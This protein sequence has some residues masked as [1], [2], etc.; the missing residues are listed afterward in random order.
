[1]KSQNISP[2]YHKLTRSSSLVDLSH[3]FLLS[4]IQIPQSEQPSMYHYMSGERPSSLITQ[5]RCKAFGTRGGLTLKTHGSSGL[6]LTLD[7]LHTA[8]RRYSHWLPCPG[9]SSLSVVRF[10][11]ATTSPQQASSP[12]AFRCCRAPP[13]QML[14]PAVAH[15]PKKKPALWISLY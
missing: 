14:V 10:A 8:V 2:S 3:S 12:R 9:S 5:S 7:F 4:V 13:P 15:L 11:R 6:C 1:M